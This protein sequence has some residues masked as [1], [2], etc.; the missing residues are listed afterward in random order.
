MRALRADILRPFD[1][2]FCI[3]D[4]LIKHA[5]QNLRNLCADNNAGRLSRGDPL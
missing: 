5:G 2:I 3:N 1:E 4:W